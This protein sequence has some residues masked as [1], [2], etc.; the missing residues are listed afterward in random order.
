MGKEKH[1]RRTNCVV[2]ER[3]RERWRKRER[4]RERGK[5]KVSEGGDC[6]GKTIVT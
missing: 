6:G 4:E 3:Q 1:G 2:H 5:Q